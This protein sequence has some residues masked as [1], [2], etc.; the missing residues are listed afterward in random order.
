MRYAP[1][2]IIGRPTASRALGEGDYER[3][4]APRPGEPKFCARC[5]APLEP[6]HDGGR[7]RPRCPRCGWTYYA[8]P[9]LGAAVLIEEKGRILLVRRAH[10]PQRGWWMLPAGYVEYGEDVRQTRRW[11][12]QF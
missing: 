11:R 3:I 9:A 4:D 5:A 10:E 2:D 8:K 12:E 1:A 7:A 6:R